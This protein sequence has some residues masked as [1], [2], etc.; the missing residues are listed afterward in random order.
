M[1]KVPMMLVHDSSRRCDVI[2]YQALCIYIRYL[3]A[4][5]GAHDR[6]GL[7]KQLLLA[8]DQGWF[9]EALRVVLSQIRTP[10]ITGHSNDLVNNECDPH[11]LSRTSFVATRQVL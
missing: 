11:L 10:D 6:E 2:T 3:V 5:V 4:D 7:N 8:K 9:Q 1:C